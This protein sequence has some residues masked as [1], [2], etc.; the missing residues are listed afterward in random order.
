MKQKKEQ[1][2][3]QFALYGCRAENV[4]VQKTDL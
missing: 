4:F 3:W 2:L 1:I